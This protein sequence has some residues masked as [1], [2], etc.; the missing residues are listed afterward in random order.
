MPTTEAHAGF[1]YPTAYKDQD[2]R[3]DGGGDST[4]SW[5]PLLLLPLGLR[6]SRPGR[7]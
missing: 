2:C 4:L 3:C 5:L 7:G 1:F 6:R